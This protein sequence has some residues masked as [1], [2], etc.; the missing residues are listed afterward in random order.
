MRIN[1]APARLVGNSLSRTAERVKENLYDLQCAFAGPRSFLAPQGRIICTS[2]GA[3]HQPGL[4]YT[5]FKRECVAQP[6]QSLVGTRRRR[7]AFPIPVS[8][9]LREWTPIADGIK[10]NVGRSVEFSLTRG[11]WSPRGTPPLQR[12]DQGVFYT[13]TAAGHP[14]SS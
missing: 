12:A 7:C 5:T 2:V 11:I 1:P 3:Y 9:S 8:L 6:V 14:S 13:V 4:L 10:F